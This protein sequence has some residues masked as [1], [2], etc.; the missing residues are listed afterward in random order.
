M[1]DSKPRVPALSELITYWGRVHPPDKELNQIM[2]IHA[3]RKENLEHKSDMGARVWVV[4]EA[5]LTE[6]V[7]LS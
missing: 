5:E 6:K 2:Q 3:V 7:T 4:R 1:T